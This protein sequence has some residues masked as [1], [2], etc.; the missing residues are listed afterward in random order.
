MPFRICMLRFYDHS[1]SRVNGNLDETAKK[2][3]GALRRPPYIPALKDGGLRRTWLNS[4]IYHSGTAMEKVTVLCLF[5]ML[6][7]SGCGTPKPDSGEY[8][9]IVGAIFSMS[10]PNDFCVPDKLL[11]NVQKLQS[12]L[13]WIAIYEGGVEDNNNTIRMMAGVEDEANRFVGLV[14]TTTVSA[15]YC[16]LKLDSM[17][18]TLNL[19]LK[20]QGLKK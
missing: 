14:N 11:A 15:A 2:V 3:C 13:H 1:D 19:V 16:K 18:G 20:A 4:G 7:L 8:T 12:D 6:S 9:K 10:V 17:T 5:C